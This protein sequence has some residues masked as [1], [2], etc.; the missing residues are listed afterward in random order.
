MTFL[1]SILFKSTF[2]HTQITYK[3]QNNESLERAARTTESTKRGYI[4][5]HIWRRATKE[6]RFLKCVFSASFLRSAT[7][8]PRLRSVAPA[9]LLR[10]GTS[11]IYLEK[12]EETQRMRR[13]SWDAA[14]R[15]CNA[16]RIAT[17]ALRL[18]FSQQAER[19]EV[20]SELGGKL[21]NCTESDDWEQRAKLVYWLQLSFL[22]CNFWTTF[23]WLV[24][25]KYLSSRYF[26][27]SH[28]CQL[29]AR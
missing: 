20:S 12:M 10:W 25:K 3:P 28:N 7:S 15:S 14:G 27:G 5:A 18:P 4:R 17:A 8:A 16:T 6:L 13:R 29:N 9:L 1:V 23:A 24:E 2:E 26:P 21:V 19:S 11:R 22:S